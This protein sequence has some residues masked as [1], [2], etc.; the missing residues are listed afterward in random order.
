MMNLDQQKEQF[1]NAF[2]H[3]IAAVSECSVSK[4]NVDDDSVDWT[5]LKRIQRRRRIDLQLKCTGSAE[6]VTQNGISFGLKKK[7]YDDL[8]LVD[9]VVPR[10]LVVVFSWLWSLFLKMLKCG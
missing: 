1:S 7:N 3:A 2:L 8:R 4:P 9:L 10:I 6:T 5:L